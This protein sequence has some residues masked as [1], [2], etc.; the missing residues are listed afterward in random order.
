MEKNFFI[1]L[2]L[3]VFYNCEELKKYNVEP[4]KTI[5]INDS[6]ACI[7]FKL[8]EE[9][10][11]ENPIYVFTKSDVEKSQM[12][13]ALYYEFIDSCDS[14]NTCDENILSKLKEN[15]ELSADY[16]NLYGFYYE[17]K[18]NLDDEKHR[19]LYVQYKGFNGNTIILHYSDLNT[20]S[21]LFG[22]FIFFVVIFAI[23]G[24]I[25]FCIWRCVR[26]NNLIKMNSQF[27][28]VQFQAENKT[29]LNNNFNYNFNYN[30]KPGIPIVPEDSE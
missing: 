8:G 3:L 21:V 24:A 22:T 14:K 29:N 9:Q 20:K 19:A 16:E 13:K 12:E 7:C 30:Y 23:I 26:T 15:R 11:K 28:N 25:I 2:I 1:L 17:F 4:F 10:K 5:E 6:S 27:K 18:F